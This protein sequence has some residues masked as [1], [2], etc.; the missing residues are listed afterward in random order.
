MATSARAFWC[1]ACQMS[2]H[3]VPSLGIELNLVL[4]RADPHEPCWGR[5]PVEADHADGPV[6][7]SYER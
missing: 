1:A 4:H 6:L 2:F 3:G 5:Y 7:A